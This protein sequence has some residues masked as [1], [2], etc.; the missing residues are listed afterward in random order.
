MFWSPAFAVL[1][2]QSITGAATLL[3]DGATLEEE[4]TTDE[5]WGGCTVLELVG[6]VSASILITTFV[7]TS[8]F[9]W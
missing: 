1:P 8:A 2:E 6:L 7:S 9:A 4:A 3:E 5:L